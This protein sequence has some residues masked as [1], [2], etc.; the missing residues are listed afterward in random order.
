MKYNIYINQKAYIDSGFEGFDLI[1][2]ALFD[3]IHDYVNNPYC[4][5]HVLNGNTYY[6]ISSQ[7]IMDEMPLL[8]IKSKKGIICRMNKLIECDLIRRCEEPQNANRA[9]FSI[10][11]NWS[12]FKFTRGE[13]GLLPESNTCYPKDTGVLP[14]SNLGVTERL[15]NNNI[16]YNQYNIEKKEEERKETQPMPIGNK[17]SLK[18]QTYLKMKESYL[19]EVSSPEWRKLCEQWLDYKFYEKG[20]TY[21][22]LS[23]FSSFCKDLYSKSGG[24]LEL[25]IDIIN[26]SM[27][28]LWKGIFDPT[29]EMKA[30]YNNNLN[31][32]EQWQLPT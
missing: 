6:H 18:E 26:W 23:T 16:I 11:S 31:Q 24:K 30:K 27:C 4:E 29:A 22:T 2:L 15:H 9:L 12:I 17:V 3:F 19:K 28:N 21:K 20:E 14:E 8:N 10:G 32:N 5:K 13:T 1:D 25:A 7:K